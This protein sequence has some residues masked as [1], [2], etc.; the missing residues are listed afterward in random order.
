MPELLPKI[1]TPEDFVRSIDSL[2]SSHKIDYIEAIV[3]YCERNNIEI[4]TA[5]SLIKSNARIKSQLQT[6]AESLN[7][8]PKTSK[9]P[10]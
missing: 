10:I 4:E 5:A 7:L 8:L 9:L 3:L 1:K 2:V 6:E